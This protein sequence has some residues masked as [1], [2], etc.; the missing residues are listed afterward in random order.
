MRLFYEL[1]G[2]PHY[3]ESN[4]ERESYIVNDEEN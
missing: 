4:K 2:H 1:A 3:P